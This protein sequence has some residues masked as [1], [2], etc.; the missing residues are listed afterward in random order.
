MKIICLFTIF[1]SLIYQESLNAKPNPLPSQSFYERES[2]DSNLGDILPHFFRRPEDFD[3]D[4]ETQTPPPTPTFTS[5]LS[6]FTLQYQNGQ[7]QSS[8]SREQEHM[9]TLRL[10]FHLFYEQI[11]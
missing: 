2:E 1:V 4:D 11:L 10:Y 3:Y 8:A 9:L 6:I 5:P 7:H